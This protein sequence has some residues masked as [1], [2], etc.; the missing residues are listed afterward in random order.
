MNYG[1]ISSVINEKKV[2]NES[3]INVVISGRYLSIFGLNSLTCFW[4]NCLKD[5]SN[6]MVEI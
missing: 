4:E 1:C 6:S 3:V 2:C 5:Y